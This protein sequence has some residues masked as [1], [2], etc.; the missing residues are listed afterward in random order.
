MIFSP[1]SAHARRWPEACLQSELWSQ[2]KFN[3]FLIQL[4]PASMMT[5]LSFLERLASVRNL[6]L[7]KDLPLQRDLPQRHNEWDKKVNVYDLVRD[8]SWT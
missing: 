1:W 3:K 8:L 4:R 6:P 5:L 2:W 7:A